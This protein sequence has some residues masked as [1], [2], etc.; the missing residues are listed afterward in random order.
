MDKT[1]SSVINFIK[2]NGSKSRIISFA[3]QTL[4]KLPDI[5]EIE[6]WRDLISADEERAIQKEAYVGFN[7]ILEIGGETLWCNRNIL[8][9]FMIHSTHF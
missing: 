3:P 8:F 5:E 4:I 6:M 1:R 7:N 2:I 9:F